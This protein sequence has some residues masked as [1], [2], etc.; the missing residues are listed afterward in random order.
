MALWVTSI[1]DGIASG[2]QLTKIGGGR[3]AFSSANIF[4][5][6]AAALGVQGGGLVFTC[7]SWSVIFGFQ[8]PLQSGS[9]ARSAQSLR[10]R[11][12]IDDGRRLLGACP[13]F[14][15]ARQPTDAADASKRQRQE[16]RVNSQGASPRMIGIACAYLGCI[17]VAI[18]LKPQAQCKVK[19][20]QRPKATTAI[21]NSRDTPPAIRAGAGGFPAAPQ[22]AISRPANA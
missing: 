7:A 22:P 3:P 2:R 10:G 16:N 14:A 11:R 8:T 21:H 19:P 20:I 18:I 1:Q 15:T 13:R 4:S 6:R 9:L 17:E 5:I 12:R